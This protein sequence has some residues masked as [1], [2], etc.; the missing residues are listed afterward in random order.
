MGNS[1]DLSERKLGGLL[2]KVGQTF[3]RRFL[4]EKGRES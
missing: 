2:E 3:S 1:V 4:R